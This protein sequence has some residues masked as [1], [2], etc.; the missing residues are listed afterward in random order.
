MGVFNGEYPEDLS[1]L[2]GHAKR[3]MKL[4]AKLERAR[5]DRWFVGRS[6]EV[7]GV[8]SLAIADWRSGT[9]DLELTGKNIGTYIDTLHRGASK[10]LRCGL[11]LECCSIDDVITAV[12][13][14]EAMRSAVGIDTTATLAPTQGTSA[15]TARQPWADSPEMLTRVKE[16]EGLVEVCARI[17]VRTTGEAYATMD[18][19][20]GFGR[21]GLLDAARAFDERRGVPFERWASLRIRSAIIDGVRRW[22]PLP[23][24]ARR[25]LQA[26]EAADS[27]PNGS[28]ASESSDSGAGIGPSTRDLRGGVGSDVE[29]LGGSGPSPE[30]A[31]ARAQFASLVREIVASLPAREREL[32]ERS[33]FNG[34]TLE[35]AAASMGVTRAWARRIHARAMETMQRA[36]RKREGIRVVAK[37]RRPLPERS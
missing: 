20:R 32:V 25:E 5:R 34:Q 8:V 7:R 22:G 16:G 24:K 36:L 10:K 21:E 18:D 15:P 23:A 26:L 28:D 31:M 3:L 27:M 37:D 19:L 4:L 9:R 30:D 33:Y 2:I 6:T 11:A 35:Q 17:V 14:D 13:G 12:A 1:R 29:R